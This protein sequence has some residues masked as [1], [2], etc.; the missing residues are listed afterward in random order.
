MYYGGQGGG[1]GGGCFA[2][3][4]GH[5]RA[6]VFQVNFLFKR[7]IAREWLGSAKIFFL[8]SESALLH[9]IAPFKKDVGSK[10]LMGAPC[11]VCQSHLINLF[12]DFIFAIFSCVFPEATP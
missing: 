4:T 10:P 3:Y 12:S 9:H 6:V 7:C 5:E 8:V 11:F 1:K 2:R